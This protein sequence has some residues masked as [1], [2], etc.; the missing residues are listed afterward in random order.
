MVTRNPTKLLPL[1]SQTKLTLTLTL[2]LNP[3]AKLTLERGTKHTKPSRP[4]EP[5]EMPFGATI[6]VNVLLA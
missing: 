5:I 6:F 3:K 4:A 1:T 2:T